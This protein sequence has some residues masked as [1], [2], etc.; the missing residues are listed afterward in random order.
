MAGM[1]LADAITYTAL[2]QA[3]IGYLSAFSW[4]DILNT[5]YSGEIAADL[6]KPMDYFLHWLGR[7]LGRAAAAFLTRGVTIMLAYQVA[8]GIVYPD[9]PLQWF[10]LGIAIVLSWLLSFSWRFIVNLPAFWIPNAM[11]IGRFF[12]LT[13]LFLSGFMMP[14]RF[15]PDWVVKLAYLTPFPHTVNTIVEVYL[16][17]LSPTDLAL[18]FAAQVAWIIGLVIL[19]QLILGRG[20]RRLVILGG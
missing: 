6:L 14:L 10:H 18:A 15:F 4:Y 5:V 7:D 9:S 13:S 16:G 12:F 3:V 1:S 2:T 19:G 17:L 20:M 8:I 11:G